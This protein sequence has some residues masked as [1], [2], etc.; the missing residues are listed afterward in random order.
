MHKNPEADR[1][2]DQKPTD[3]EPEASP[4]AGWREVY[5]TYDV[6][7]SIEP[8]DECERPECDE[9]EDVE[10]CIILGGDEPEVR[11]TCPTHWSKTLEV[12]T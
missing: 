2:T 4:S 9:D 1:R 5:E 11:V 6:D 12:S 3:L 7:P 10:L 8:A